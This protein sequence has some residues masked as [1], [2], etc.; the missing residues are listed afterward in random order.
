M[1]VNMQRVYL[2]HE[3]KLEKKVQI[4]AYSNSFLLLGR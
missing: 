2:F 3:H 1:T 4:A